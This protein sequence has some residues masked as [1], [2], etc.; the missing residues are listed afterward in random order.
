[1]FENCYIQTHIMPLQ[2]KAKKEIV[3]CCYEFRYVFTWAKGKIYLTSFLYIIT[4]FTSL[5][6]LSYIDCNRCRFSSR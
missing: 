5:V 4:N 1:M 6:G 3:Y 2:T